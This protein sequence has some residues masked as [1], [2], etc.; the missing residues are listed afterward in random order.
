MPVLNPIDHTRLIPAWEAGADIKELG[1][2][3]DLMADL[4]VNHV[5]SSS[6]HNS[7]IILKKVMH[8]FYKDLFLT[9]DS[10]FPDGAT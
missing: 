10:I 6:R 1:Q 5:S 8:P 3:V 4:I 7:W 9:M 2:D